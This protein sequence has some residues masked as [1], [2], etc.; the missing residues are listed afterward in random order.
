MLA[1]FFVS[2]GTVFA[3]WSK[4]GSADFLFKVFQRLFVF[5]RVSVPRI[6]A[7]RSASYLL[8]AVA[9]DN[10]ADRRESR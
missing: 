9:E 5:I 4:T 7:R 1:S 3:L 8:L 6:E 10:A 2:K